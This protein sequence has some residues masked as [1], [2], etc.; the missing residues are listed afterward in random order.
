VFE[1]D[2]G[3]RRI[4]KNKAYVRINQK[5]FILMS[6]NEVVHDCENLASKECA[7]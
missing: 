3:S 1:K 2:N 7:I 6:S 4:E 5:P